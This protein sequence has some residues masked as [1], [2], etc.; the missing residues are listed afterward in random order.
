VE[1]A[2]AEA[3]GRLV[4]G[5]WDAIQRVVF[6][7]GRSI[8]VPKLQTGLGAGGTLDP[9]LME[10]EGFSASIMVPI[11]TERKVYG[12]FC[13][14]ASRPSVFDEDDLTFGT[15]V[16][17]RLGIALEN[18]DLI[19]ELRAA[20]D[21]RDEFIS[22]ATHEL[23]TPLAIL[24][25]YAQLLQKK[26]GGNLDRQ[27]LSAIEGQTRRLN[28]LVNELL[29]VSRLQMGRLDL[30]RERFD[31]V[32]LVRETVERFGLLT[33]P[34]EAPRLKTEFLEPH[35]W[36]NWDRGRIEQAL[37]NLI[38]NALKY[39]PEGGEVVVE[40]GRRG[41]EAMVS[42]RDQGI[43]IPTEQQDRIFEPFVRAANARLKKIE[44][45]GLGL[46]ISKEIVE[47]NGGRMWFTSDEGKGST[48]YLTLP[49]GD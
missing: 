18:A 38:S 44:G 7:E 43:G 26:K 2:R 42:V 11:K 15:L 21:S 17:E 19:R 5:S 34:G 33:P 14:L 22:I 13:S 3:A 10:R 31:L 49:L 12:L 9:S 23:K 35:L 28:D 8:F 24:R 4:D 30:T 16:A 1:P 40:V 6:G 37:T 41:A 32:E 46:H 27:A 36:G 25:G 48:F 47:R 45:A 39:S 20:L 29:D